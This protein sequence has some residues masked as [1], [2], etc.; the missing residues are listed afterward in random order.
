LK[1]LIS[2]AA[3]IALL[4]SG[5]AVANA[6]DAYNPDTRQSQAKD[7]TFVIGE[8]GSVDTYS[9][10]HGNK[11][12]AS[13]RSQYTCKSIYDSAC[14]GSDSF[15]AQSILGVCQAETD[16]NCVVKLELAGSDSVFREAKYVRSTTG[17]TYKPVPAMNYIG[18][19]TPSLWEIP[20][21]PSASGTTSYSVTVRVS[22][23]TGNPGRPFNSESM[24]AAVVP[25]KQIDGNYID[26]YAETVEKNHLGVRG[27]GIGGHD[28]GCAWN[29]VGHCGVAQDFAPG[30]KVRLTVRLPKELSGWYRGR[31]KDPTFDAKP[32]SKKNNLV[33][34]GAEPA[35][36][37]RFSVT[38]PISEL[39]ETEKA[40]AN[41]QG[42][43]GGWEGGFTTW[44]R[45]SDNPTF[46]ILE[47]FRKSINDTSKG[48]NTLW[49]FATINA[50]SNSRCLND[51]SRVLGIVTTN[52]M[53]YDGGVPAYK[54]GF[55]NYQVAGLHYMPDGT[56]LAIGTYDMVIRSDVARCLY[57]FSKAPLSATVSVINDKGAKTTATTVVS[58]KNGWLKLAA[59]G[60]TF[61]KKTIKVKITKK[62]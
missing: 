30:T 55:L 33:T 21:V 28:V 60:F 61:S 29:E 40:Y 37:P 15:Q 5:S 6:A 4:L 2:I 36:V 34:I 8:E 18:A 51:S 10:L 46:G 24:V 19:S 27:I 26:P 13:G 12:T 38:K 9:L 1:K 41:R 14:A 49:N 47:Y 7:A 25:Y 16:E 57:G 50:N 44:S 43:A 17:I 59:Y 11:K 35:T 31:L 45:A 54:G 53:V 56:E 58:E 23:G 22:N 3:T 52:S 48:V 20:E 39:N 42:M 32:F 62:K